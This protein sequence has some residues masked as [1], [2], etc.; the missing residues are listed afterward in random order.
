MKSKNHIH[1]FIFFA[2][3]FIIIYIILA[4]RPLNKEYNFTPEWKK[5]ISSPSVKSISADTKK[6]YFKLGQS[7]GYF[8]EDDQIT[9]FIIQM[10]K[11][12]PFIITKT[13]NRE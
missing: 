7:I 4:A 9:P 12:L 1:L 11:I 5:S 2:I 8:T 10:P 3:I 13:R 6:I